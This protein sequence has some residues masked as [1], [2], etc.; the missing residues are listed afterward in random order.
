M[1]GGNKSAGFTLLELLSILMLLGILSAVAVSKLDINPFRTAGFEQ[2]LRAAI[3]FAQKF[4]IVSGCEVQVDVSAAS[5]ALRV[6]NDAAANGC[7]NAVQPFGALLNNPAGGTFTAAP[8]SGVVVSAA[9]FTYDRQGRPSANA[10]I[11][12]DTRTIIVH[13]VTGYVQ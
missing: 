2:E 3:R 5:Y 11:T 1:T 8:P 4:A 10:S 12:V 13:A 9:T 7:L 6:R